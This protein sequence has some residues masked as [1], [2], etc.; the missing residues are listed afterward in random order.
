MQYQDEFLVYFKVLIYK[1]ALIRRICVY[2]RM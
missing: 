2:K 1:T